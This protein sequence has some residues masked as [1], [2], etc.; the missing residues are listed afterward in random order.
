MGKAH[1]IRRVMIQKLKRG[2]KALGLPTIYDRVLQV[3]FV[4]ALELESESTFE[5]NSHGFCSVRSLIYTIKQIKLF[6]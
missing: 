3:L 4:R 2:F 1:S 5:R 6:L